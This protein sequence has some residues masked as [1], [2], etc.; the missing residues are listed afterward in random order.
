MSQFVA[1]LFPAFV[2]N[3]TR[4][5]RPAEGVRTSQCRVPAALPSVSAQL[6][7]GPFVCT[8]NWSIR[9]SNDPLNQIS[10]YGQYTTRG[11]PRFFRREGP[12]YQVQPPASP[13]GCGAGLAARGTRRGRGNL[14]LHSDGLNLCG[15]LESCATAI[16]PDKVDDQ[17]DEMISHDE[18]PVE[19]GFLG[20]G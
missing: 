19:G 13:W 3:L 20:V 14:N 6:L 16:V 4:S 2:R 8:A 12:P 1:G 7:G 10:A 15:H 5:T 11:A 17:M 9:R 18:F